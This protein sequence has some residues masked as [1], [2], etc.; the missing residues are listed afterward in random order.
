MAK[1]NYKTTQDVI[2]KTV[3]KSA[4]A[5]IEEEAKELV[6]MVIFALDKEEYAVEISEV[7]EILRMP[8]ITPMPNAPG[9]IEGIINVRG[10]IVVVIDLEKRF[11]LDRE[12][13]KKSLNVVL[14]EIGE[15]TFGAVVDEVTEVLRVPKDNIESAPAIISEKIHADYV[16]GIVVLEGRLI[17]LLD[18]LKVFEEKGLVDLGELVQRQ[19][20]SSRAR[21]IQ[22]E[23]IEKKETEA[24]RKIKIEQMAAEH[25]KKGKKIPL[26]Q[27]EAQQKKED[28][29]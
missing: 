9:F 22:E 18:L 1:L 16:K 4:G 29:K 8:E 12:S 24:E 11:N 28:K 21:R 19:A 5:K 23:P 26:E 15:N 10:K 25:I 2:E 20:K 3:S 14:A 13:E 17:I 27:K 7:R 6:Q